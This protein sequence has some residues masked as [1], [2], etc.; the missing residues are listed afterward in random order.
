MDSRIPIHQ[1]ILTI[2]SEE[3]LCYRGREYVLRIPMAINQPPMSCSQIISVDFPKYR[4]NIYINVFYEYGGK[5]YE[6][7]YY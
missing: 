5:I 6:K 7:A 1:Q 3:R 2:A 4:G